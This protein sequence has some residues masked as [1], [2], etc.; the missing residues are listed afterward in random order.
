MG[1]EN[2]QHLLSSNSAQRI[3][4][5]YRIGR[6]RL[7]FYLFIYSM[8]MSNS[9]MQLN[10]FLSDYQKHTYEGF[11]N[12]FTKKI[13]LIWLQP[14]QSPNIKS[15]NIAVKVKVSSAKISFKEICHSPI[16]KERKKIRR[17]NRWFFFLWKRN[18]SHENQLSSP[19]I[20]TSEVCHPLAQ[21]LQKGR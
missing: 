1:F 8:E 2:H 21:A 11:K 5:S 14:E 4:M 17:T 9:L 3:F 10:A 18:Q 19:F 16:T 7:C 12:D 6:F 20:F 15:Q 13:S